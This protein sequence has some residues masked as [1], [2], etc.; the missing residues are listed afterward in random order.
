MARL[1]NAGVPASLIAVFPIAR[2][3]LLSLAALAIAALGALLPACWAARARPAD[4]L[5][6]E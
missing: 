4:A 3:A 5:R 2:L 1:G 6:T